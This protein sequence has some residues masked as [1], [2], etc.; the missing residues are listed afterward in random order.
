LA[1]L[2][3]EVIESLGR[4]PLIGRQQMQLIR[5]GRKLILLNVTP[6]GAEALAEVTDPA[7]VDRLTGLCQQQRRGSISDSFRQ[8]LS[9]YGEA[10]V[11]G[12]FL[13][14]VPSSAN[15]VGGKS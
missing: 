15:A 5:L 8:V 4:A 7:E 2:P 12:G 13:G 6:H 3:E 9:Q 14:T 1:R 10:P 11:R